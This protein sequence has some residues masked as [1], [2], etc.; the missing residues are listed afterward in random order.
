MKITSLKP[1]NNSNSNSNSNSNIWMFHRIKIENNS[2]SDIYKNRGMVHTIDE[3]CC[4]I[5]T[6][7][8]AGYK[9]GSISEALNCN[10]TI[11]LTFDDGYKEHLFV[12]KMLKQ[13]YNFSYDSITFSINIRNSF[14]Q[15]KLC[16]DMV[17]QLIEKDSLYKID[18][19]LNIVT[20]DT[21]LKTIKNILFSTTAYITDF[22]KLVDMKNYF[23]NKEE[24]LSLSKL[25][26]IASHCVNHCYLTSFN[27][28][29]IYKEL[30]NSKV[31]LS[32]ILNTEVNT[33]CYPD[34]KHSKYINNISK[35]IGYTFGLSISP[36]TNG[37]QEFNIIRSIP[38]CI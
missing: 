23:L 15:D 3:L 16:M 18:S 22:N 6:S 11:H 7:I 4:L 27:K 8:M 31:Y 19:L 37:P 25:F 24:L 32:S 10:K 30:K 28:D 17:Y 13:K 12:A 9:F 2:I 33:I 36:K 34:G 20:N 38:Q 5:D 1:K 21:E 14:Y 35:E 26:S 29:D